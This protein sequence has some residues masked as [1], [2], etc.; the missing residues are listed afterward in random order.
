MW[1]PPEEHECITFEE[2]PFPDGHPDSRMKKLHEHDT[3]GDVQWNRFYY[4][5]QTE[6][7]NKCPMYDVTVIDQ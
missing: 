5:L 3:T 1:T 2:M 7:E 6:E 4:E